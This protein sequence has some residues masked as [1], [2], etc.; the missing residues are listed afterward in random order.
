VVFR[1]S[2]EL[3]ERVNQRLPEEK[4]AAVES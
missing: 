4:S 2:K 1:P 3:R